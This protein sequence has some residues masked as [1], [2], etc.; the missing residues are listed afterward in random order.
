[1]RN[2]L[3]ASHGP[4]GVHVLH[5]ERLHIFQMSVRDDAIDQAGDMIVGHEP[6]EDLVQ[7]RRDALQSRRRFR[8]RGLRPD[9]K[10]KGRGHDRDRR[11]APGFTKHWHPL[12]SALKRLRAVGQITGPPAV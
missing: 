8:G 11:D 3:S 1:M 4:L 6:G 9:R 7:L 12:S 2:R 5:A 10:N